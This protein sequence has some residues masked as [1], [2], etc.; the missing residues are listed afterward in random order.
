MNKLCTIVML[1]LALAAIAHG[2]DIARL[3]TLDMEIKFSEVAHT[4]ES[5]THTQTFRSPPMPLHFGE[6]V[7][8]DPAKTPLQMPAGKYVLSSFYAEIV[9]EAGVKTP[10]SEVYNHHWIVFDGKGNMGPCQSL[11]YKFGVGA[12]SRGYPIN[13]PAPYG[14][15]TDG[16]EQWSANIHLLRTVNMDPAWGVQK[17]IECHGP[18]K[19]CTAAQSGQ[20]D[21][22]DQGTWCPTVPGNSS[23]VA[24]PKTYYMQYVVGWRPIT[25]G[26]D[27]P[28]NVYVL[29]ASACQVEYNIAENPTGVHVTELSWTAPASGTLV[30]TVGHIH[31][32]GFNITFS[33]NGKEVCTSVAQYGSEVGVA[34][35]EK[36][37]V[38][39]I[40]P[41]YF[42]G[43]SAPRVEK[44]DT[45]SV[46]SLYS[47]SPTDP[48]SFA[49][50]AHECVMSLFYIAMHFD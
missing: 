27:K 8:T 42:D 47:V 17:C 3:R 30:A 24:N 1:G 23:G 40:K 32:G 38:V 12:E 18:N 10:L 41:C 19:W 31:I 9:D 7:F 22:C 28:L 37:Y 46:R 25:A 35:N 13:F 5:G 21:C 6:V 39:A 43:P 50:G 29:D 34:G 20:F 44:G 49:K 15:I 2:Y 36:G 48:R 11:G 16:T 4:V 33:V 45:V 14:T 26:V